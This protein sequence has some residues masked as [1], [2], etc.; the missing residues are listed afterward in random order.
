MP[1]NLLSSD[2]EFSFS[3]HLTVSLNGT[4]GYEEGKGKPIVLEI[5]TSHLII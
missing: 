2:D 5:F 4:Q 1:I 3:F